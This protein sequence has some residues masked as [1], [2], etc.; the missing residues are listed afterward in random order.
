MQRSTRWVGTQD[1]K[2]WLLATLIAMALLCDGGR[3]TCAVTTGGNPPPPGASTLGGNGTGGLG[4][5]PP[6]SR[7]TP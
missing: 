1:L 5:P 2:A 4:T 6:M 3:A 7:R